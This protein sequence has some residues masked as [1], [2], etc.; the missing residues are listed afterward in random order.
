MKSTKEE[1]GYRLPIECCGNCTHSY[2]TEYNETCCK[3]LQRHDLIDVG[4]ACDMWSATP[5]VEPTP[6]VP[7]ILEQV[8]EEVEDKS[9]ANCKHSYYN[10]S[11]PTCDIDNELITETHVC[12]AWEKDDDGL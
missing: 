8:T 9:C 7:D 2:F 1:I 6:E 12:N 11:E 5:V 4:G 10:L 3:L